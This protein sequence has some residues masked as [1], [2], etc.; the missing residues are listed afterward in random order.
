MN[1]NPVVPD[2]DNTED[3]GCNVY[4]KERICAHR[5]SSTNH[6]VEQVDRKDYEEEVLEGM[7]MVDGR[8]RNSWDVDQETDDDHIGK[9]LNDE[10]SEGALQLWL[11]TL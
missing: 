10:Q 3:Q 5:M 2:Q 6:A 1:I 11:R 4:R 9:Q 7:Y 8:H